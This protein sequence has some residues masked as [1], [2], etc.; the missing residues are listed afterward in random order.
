MHLC[1]EIDTVMDDFGNLIFKPTRGP[2]GD[3]GGD[4]M[5]CPL[6]REMGIEASGPAIP[7]AVQR[8]LFALLNTPF[9]RLGIYYPVDRDG[10][11]GSGTRDSGSAA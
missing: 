10:G 11:R 1:P 6:C 9:H 2:K 8:V 5:P 7:L 4:G 3:D